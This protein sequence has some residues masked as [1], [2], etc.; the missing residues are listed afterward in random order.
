M[1]RKQTLQKAK[2]AIDMQKKGHTLED[3]GRVLNLSRQRIHQILKLNFNKKVE[4]N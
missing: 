3:I 2:L 4:S 1:Q